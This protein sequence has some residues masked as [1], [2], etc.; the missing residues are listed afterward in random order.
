MTIFE[1]TMVPFIDM[2]ST[3]Q[4]KKFF[5]V[6]EKSVNCILSQGKLEIL[7]KSQGKLKF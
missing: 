7:K 5:N 2:V 1:A 3:G 6:R 4:G